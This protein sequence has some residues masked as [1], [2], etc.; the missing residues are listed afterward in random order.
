M[1]IN[2]KWVI[3]LAREGRLV[4]YDTDRRRLRRLRWALFGTWLALVG[5]SPVR[6]DAL[7]ESQKRGALRWGGDEEGGGPYIFRPENN[8]QAL[9]GFEIDLMA[10]LADRLHVQSEFRS[11]Q[12]P[13]LLNTLNT[14]AIDVVVNGYEL[15]PARLAGFLSTIPYYVY[16]LH[17]F[18]RADD[19]RLTD[20]TSLQNPRPEGGKWRVGVLKNTLADD[21]VTREFAATV[22]VSRYEGTT[23]AFRDVESRTLDA[24]V[25]DTPAATFYGPEVQSQTSRPADGQG[26]LRH[27]PAAGRRSPPRRAQRWT[28]CRPC[29]RPT[30][31][32]LRQVRSMERQPGD[33]LRSRRPK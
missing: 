32:D 7:T 3:A 13:E 19:G 21:Y 8:V 2:L 23:D 11:S 12:W 1:R 18:A 5:C 22:E 24:T 17:L 9:T 15:S 10:L 33:A 31:S 25:T 27:V 26:L 4:I 6:T 30:E 16:E 20:W 14:G 29:R 28:A